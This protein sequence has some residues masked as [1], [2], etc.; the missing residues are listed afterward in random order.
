MRSLFCQ[1]WIF[2][3]AGFV[4]FSCAGPRGDSLSID[5]DTLVTEETVSVS[6][7]SRTDE[8]EVLAR[9]CT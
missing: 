9:T 5:E 8:D 4:L 1:G 3:V 7:D 2:I 6:D